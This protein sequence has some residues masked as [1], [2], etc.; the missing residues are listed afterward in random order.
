L[1][2][3]ARRPLIAGTWKMNGLKASISG[4]TGSSGRAPR[5]RAK[6]DLKTDLLVCPPAP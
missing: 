6:A 1:G 5:S 4:S 2:R 3:P